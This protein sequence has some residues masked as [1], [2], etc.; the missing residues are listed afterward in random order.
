MLETLATGL[1]LA[2]A[3]YVAIGLVFA[4]YFVWR[5]AG[6]VDPAA[7]GGSWGFRV[8]IFPGAVALWPLLVRRLG[9]GHPPQE[10]YAH[11]DLARE[12]EREQ[13]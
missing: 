10:R 12:A 11:R 4:L 3:L 2:T 7:A 6:G 8:M 1:G 5:G 13:P 9:R